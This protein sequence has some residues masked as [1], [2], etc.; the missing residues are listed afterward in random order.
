LPGYAPGLNTSGADIQ[1]VLEAEAAPE[2]RNAPGHIDPAARQLIDES[3]KAGWRQFV[4]DAAKNRADESLTFDG[5]GRFVY[6]RT[7][8]LGLHETVVC[9]GESLLHLY[10]ELGLGASRSVTRF[11]RAELLAAV[12]WLTP[13]AEDLAHGADLELVGENTV[14]VVPHVVKNLKPVDGQ[15]QKYLRMQLVF[16]PRRLAERQIVEVPA[17]KVH[18]REVYD[19]EGGLRILDGDGKELDKFNQP[20]TAAPGPDLHPDTK[21]LVVLPLPLRSRQHVMASFKLDPN[22]SLADVDN[23]CYSELPPNGA[24]QLLA[25]LYA[26]GAADDARLVVRDCFLAHNDRRLGLFTLLLASGVEVGNDLDCIAALK[27]RVDQPVARYVLLHGNAPYRFLHQRWPLNVG[28]TVGEPDSFL[29]RLAEFEDLTTRNPSTVPAWLEQTVV[30]GD[31][32]RYADF[33]HRNESNVLGWAMLTHV[34]DH[35]YPRN[36]NRYKERWQ[37]L[38]GQWGRIAAALHDNPR[39]GYE[40]ASCLQSAGRPDEARKLFEDLYDKELK[41]AVLPAIDRRFR[42]A[43]VGDDKHPDDW[44]RLVRAT[45]ADFLKQDRRAAVIALAT[46]CH[47]LDDRPLADNLMQMALSDLKDEDLLG[48]TLLAVGNYRRWGDTGL[49]EKL[50]DDMLARKQFQLIPG[51]WRLA[52]TIADERGATEK[53]I[54]CLEHAL[55]LEFADLPDV[56]DLQ[57]WRTDYG[58]LLSHY[59]SVVANARMQHQLPPPDLAAL[60]IRAVDRWRKHDPEATGASETASQ[61]LNLLGATNIAWDYLTTS[62]GNNPTNSGTWVTVAQRLQ[63]QGDFELADRAYATAF[64]AN[65]K[66]PLILWDRAQNRRQAGDLAGANALLRQIENTQWGGAGEPSYDNI[67][68]NARWQLE[69]K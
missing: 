46:Q 61:I 50:V 10:P 59:R 62:V 63:R 64:E 14:A 19:G 69:S 60:T 31:R 24:L 21:A 7:L 34:Q 32:T 25:T 27:D 55:D 49:A 57:S 22:R 18:L 67:R 68:A 30:K 65:A 53:A 47:Q 23:G 33:I 39:A 51:L 5:A 41:A 35:R 58:R 11:H 54:R 43:L 20:L 66:D 26:Q 42:S 56:I 13:P 1:A 17:N 16:A 37:W 8:P 28:A 40:Q 48:V 36:A 2:L 6:Q 52:S 12:P 4:F 9:D 44:N 29:R 15:P 45:A 3:R 38:A